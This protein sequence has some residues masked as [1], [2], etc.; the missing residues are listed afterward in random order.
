MR[1]LPQ[2]FYRFQLSSLFSQLSYRCLQLA[3]AWWILDESADASTYALVISISTAIEIGSRLVFAWLGD[4]YDKFFVYRLSCLAN[5]FALIILAALNLFGVYHI[6]LVAGFLG[7][8]GVSLGI[9]SPIAASAISQLVATEQISK[10]VQLKNVFYSLASVA[11]PGLAGV[12]IA[13]DGTRSALITG[14]LLILCSILLITGLVARESPAT[15]PGRSDAAQ[16][17]PHPRKGQSSPW[18]AEVVNGISLLYT[19][20]AEFFLALVAMVLNLCLFPFFTI[21]IPV[22]VKETLQLDAWYIGLLD[23]SFSVG[24]LLGSSIAVEIVTRR[25]GKRR[26]AALG[27]L[28]L[29]LAMIACASLGNPYFMAPVMFLGGLGLMLFN[30]NVSVPRLIATPE[31]FK[32]RMV[33]SVLF[34][35]SIINPVGAYLSGVLVDA[36]GIHA[37]L[38]AFAAITATSAGL[39]YV[40]HDLRQVLG[41]A[42]AKLDNLYSSMYPKAFMG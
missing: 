26:A 13:V 8:I 40:S 42:D 11:G 24:I 33:A 21:L 2:R 22:L 14:C 29:A 32:N 39:L 20:K 6:L 1:N 18:W 35:S 38:I 19:V 4:H 3:M 23:G 25:L 28:L 36:A 31:A 10:A 37:T 27:I 17:Q 15:S 41:L 30:I 5:F 16:P 7:M 34:F 9:R 12:L